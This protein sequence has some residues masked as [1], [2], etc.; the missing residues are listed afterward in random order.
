M[1]DTLLGRD[2]AREA[3][4][5]EAAATERATFGRNG[6]YHVTVRR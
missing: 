1:P 5:L 3:D 4:V 2:A 6:S